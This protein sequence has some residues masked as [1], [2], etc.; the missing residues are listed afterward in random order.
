MLPTKIR[1]E[2]RSGKAIFGRINY[3]LPR[4]MVEIVFVDP[5]GVSNRQLM[6]RL[7]RN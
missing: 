7:E 5:M 4:L 3:R 1:F 2:P 6:G